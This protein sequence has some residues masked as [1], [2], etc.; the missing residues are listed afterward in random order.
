MINKFAEDVFRTPDVKT[1]EAGEAGIVK[2]LNKVTPAAEELFI[3]N[4]IGPEKVVIV[5]FCAIVPVNANS[6]VNKANKLVAFTEPPVCTT[7]FF[8]LSLKPPAELA[9]S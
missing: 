8:T 9:T 7:S 4:A 5:K 3:L 1:N 6:F 2:L